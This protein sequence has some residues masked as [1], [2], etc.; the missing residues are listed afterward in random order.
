M[1]N[2]LLI[3]FTLLLFIACSKENSEN[4]TEVELYVDERIQ[5]Y[6]DLFE[7]E[8]LARDV[9]VSLEGARVEGYIEAIEEN[10]VLGQCQYSA[11]SPRRVI[12]DEQFWAQATDLQKEFVIFHELGHCYLNRSHDDTRSNNGTCSSMMQS[13]TTRCRFSYTN[14]S[15]DAYLDELFSN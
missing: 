2:K 7:Q 6:F 4:L 11:T 12:I 13:G 8:G 14:N 10:N 1:H 9:E 15:R 3:L 5:P